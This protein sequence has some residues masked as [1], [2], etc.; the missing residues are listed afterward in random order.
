MNDDM[1]TAGRLDDLTGLQE[2]LDTFD[3]LRDPARVAFLSHVE[4][5][6]N[7]SKKYRTIRNLTRNKH[8]V[9]LRMPAASGAGARAVAAN[10]WNPHSTSRIQ[11]FE[12][13]V[14]NTAATASSPGLART[15]ARGTATTSLA[16]AIANAILNDSAAPSAPV[17]DSAW[18]VAPTV[19]AATCGQFNQAATVGNGAVINCPDPFDITPVSGMAIIT[20]IAALMPIS[21]I[22]FVFGD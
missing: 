2:L 19:A 8:Y 16:M 20:T 12:W 18:S 1:Q 7:K 15:T 14:F 9:S 6:L 4:D 10:L 22:T 11:L 13:W 5:L 17:V 21:D 3:N